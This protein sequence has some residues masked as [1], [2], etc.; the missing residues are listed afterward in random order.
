MSPTYIVKVGLTAAALTTV[1]DLI[2]ALI[3]I[4]Q[5]SRTPGMWVRI[6]LVVIA[7]LVTIAVWHS[8]M[9]RHTPPGPTLVAGLLLGW[10]LNPQSWI[11]R[12]YGGQLL[13]DTGVQSAGADLL[14]WAATAAC[15]TYVVKTR[16]ELS[17][18]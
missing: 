13:V 12:S 16:L 2:A 7:L 15:L 5:L 4:D 1:A 10:A 8:R 17:P 18:Q 6:V 9:P 11:G 14:L 3:A